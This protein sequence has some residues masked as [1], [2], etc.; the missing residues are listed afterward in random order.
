MTGVD[1]TA[2]LMRGP[3]SEPQ[4]DFAGTEAAGAEGARVGKSVIESASVGSWTTRR[5][6]TGVASPR[7][8]KGSGA[9]SSS[10]LFWNHI[11]HSSDHVSCAN[12]I[13]K[14]YEPE[15]QLR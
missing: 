11:Y 6:L 12:I 13:E 2:A 5:D 10:C 8:G 3:A 4:A 9:P 7:E 1:L 14:W 15:V